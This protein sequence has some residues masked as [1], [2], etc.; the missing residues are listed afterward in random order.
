MTNKYDPHDPLSKKVY[1]WEDGQRIAG[2]EIFK[3][4]TVT[5]WVRKACKYYRV[6][7]PKLMWLRPT[8]KTSGYYPPK[9]LIGFVP[10]HKNPVV[11]LHETAHHIADELLGSNHGP[12]H[13]S[14]W[15]AIY[16]WLLLKFEVYEPSFLRGSLKA[17]RLT[18]RPL[19]PY[20]C[21]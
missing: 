9:K 6:R 16:C 7:P 3:S 10:F 13:S 2:I 11:V 20:R 15:F 17:Y 12:D 14:Y 4:A 1:D 18:L 19:P 8:A 5:R 21:R